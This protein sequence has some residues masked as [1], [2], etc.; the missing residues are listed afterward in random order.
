LN[1]I[2]T[3]FKLTGTMFMLALGV[4][5]ASCARYDPE[6]ELV[7]QPRVMVSQGSD[8]LTP[9]YMA[10][11]YVWYITERE[12]LDNPWRPASWADAEA[13]VVRHRTSGEMRSFGLSGVQGEEDG[14]IHVPLTRSPVLLV[15]VDPVNRFYAWRTFEFKIPLERVLVP[16]TFRTYYNADQIP[17]REEEWT[18]MSDEL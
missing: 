12:Y 15:A 1:R 11:L 2:G 3:I 17:Y 18:V 14:F 8:P 9:A 13:G 16:V 6:C 10:R 7:L 5:L 4:V